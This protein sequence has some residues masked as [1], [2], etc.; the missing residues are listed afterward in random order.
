MPTPALHELS[1]WDIDK[2]F[3]DNPLF[4]GCYTQDK[5]PRLG[6]LAY[7]VNLQPSYDGSGSHWCALINTRPSHVYWY[8]ST[9]SPAPPAV[10]RRMVET[11]KK[12]VYSQYAEQQLATITCGFYACFVIQR[13]LD[14]AVWSHIIKDELQPARYQAN[15][16][17]VVSAYRK[18]K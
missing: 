5:L 17:H 18:S 3:A 4:G 10:L 6:T 9:G 16:C 12:V 14:S 2:H 7:V 11:G 15:S 1:N 13:M 8:D